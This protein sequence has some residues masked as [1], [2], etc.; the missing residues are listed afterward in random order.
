M[1]NRGGKKRKCTT[2]WLK[3]AGPD[4]ANIDF[5]KS[6]CLALSTLQAAG[7]CQVEHDEI[8]T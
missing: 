6:L 1:Q 2:G 4:C 5:A 7:L 3:A 8:K